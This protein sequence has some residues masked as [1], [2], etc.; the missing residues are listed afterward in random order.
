MKK[1]LILMTALFAGTMLINDVFALDCGDDEDSLAT[2]YAPVTN[3]VNPPQTNVNPPQAQS[4]VTHAAPAPVTN[5]NQLQEQ[6][7]YTEHFDSENQQQE[8][9]CKKIQT[10]GD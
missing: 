7:N 4:N 5:A 1:N 6:S 3:A 10:R 2:K 9:I 8:K